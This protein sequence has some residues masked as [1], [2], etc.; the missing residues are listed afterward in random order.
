MGQLVIAILIGIVWR[1][2]ISV[3]YD[4][5]SGTN[6][7]SKKLLRL[8]IIL[9]G[10]RLNLVDIVKVGP[11][12]LVISVIV[13]AFTLVLIYTLTRVFD[14]EKRLGILTACGTAIC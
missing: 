2:I 8:W 7:A 1:A 5:I 11:K 9:L 13:I 4:A 12:V 14:V 3:P 10:M 6:F